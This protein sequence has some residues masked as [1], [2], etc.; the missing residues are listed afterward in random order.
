MLLK[1]S[2]PCSTSYT[3]LEL[4]VLGTGN[5]GGPLHPSASGPTSEAFWTPISQS[6]D[7]FMLP[8]LNLTPRA[9][10]TM[11]SQEAFLILGS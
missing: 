8:H 7:A 2:C 6:A 9:V 4:A 5:A 11:L 1:A 10:Q 3:S